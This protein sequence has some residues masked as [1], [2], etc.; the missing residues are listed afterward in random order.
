MPGRR[1]P[2]GR[3]AEVGVEWANYYRPRPWLTLD[4]DLSLSRARFSDA[5]PAGAPAFP[6]RSPPWSPQARR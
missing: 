4:A 1:R 5:D 3:A 2:D 6:V